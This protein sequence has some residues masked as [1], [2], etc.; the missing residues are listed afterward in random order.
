MVLFLPSPNWN[1]AMARKLRKIQKERKHI[2]IAL[3]DTKSSKFYIQT[4]LKDKSI[5]PH[6]VFAKHIGT[7]PRSVLNAIKR[8]EKENPEI[9]YDKAWLVIDRDSFSKE[10]F[11]GTIETA[12]QKEICVAYSNE[13]YELWLLLHFKDV[14][15]HKTREEIKK[16]LN[17]E[18]QKNFGLKYDK[19]EKHV[20]G[21]LI[22][23]QEEA[24]KRANKLIENLLKLNGKLNPYND[25]PST[26]IH[27]LVECLNNLDKCRENDYSSCS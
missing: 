19:S 25:N 1:T 12:R 7:D 3:E 18:F 17:S 9:K 6:I 5:A 26:K 14:N 2:L 23:R 27:L 22:D 13:C 11:K 15:S 8:F 24:I 10:N 4:L 16:E 21:M 20:Y